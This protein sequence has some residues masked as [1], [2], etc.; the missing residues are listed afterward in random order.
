MRN[1]DLPFLS[2]L[3]LCALSSQALAQGAPLQLPSSRT[4]GPA[5]KAIE[6]SATPAKVP[7][8]DGAAAIQKANAWL[9]ANRSMIGDFTQTGADGKRATGKFYVD[10]PGKMRFIYDK[11]STL[12]ITAD[13]KSVQILDHKLPNDPATYFIWQTPLKFLLKDKIDIASDTKVKD[14]SATSAST[15]IV[16]EDNATLGGGT[17]RIKLVFD[18]LSSMLREWTVTDPQGYETNV[19]VANLDFARKPDPA[20]FKINYERFSQ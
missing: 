4:A 8:M 17:S 14:V 12:D 9:N 10:R 16:I 18:P 3:A 19:K 5:Q 7:T 13:G 15:T 2:V 1:I 11:P 6:R 20:L